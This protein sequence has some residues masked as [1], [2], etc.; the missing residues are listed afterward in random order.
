MS[1]ELKC[2]PLCEKEKF[3]PAYLAKDRHYGIPGRHSIVRCA[4]CSLV[5]LN[6][7]YSDEEL[8]ALYPADYYAYQ[9]RS[10]RKPWK[11]FLKRW[12]GMRIGTRDPVFEKPG[13][14]LDLG[15]G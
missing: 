6:P 4:G 1:V 10:S 11:D 13:V 3:D 12:L 15:C 8:G 5:F 2:C 14:M 9:D 7:M